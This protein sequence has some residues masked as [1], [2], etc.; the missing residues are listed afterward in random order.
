MAR[1]VLYIIECRDSSL[2]TGITTDIQKRLQS[3]NEGKA[4]KYTRIRRPV[5]IVYTEDFAT[6][7][8]ARRREAKVKSFSR[9]EKLKLVA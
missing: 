5:K 6:E 4:S 8:S 2:Y 3:H 1:W 9:E 7:S